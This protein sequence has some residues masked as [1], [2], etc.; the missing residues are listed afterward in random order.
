MTNQYNLGNIAK[1]E[2]IKQ[3]PPTPGEEKQEEMVPLSMLQTLIEEVEALKKG[4]KNLEEKKS[5]DEPESVP[6]NIVRLLEHKDKLVIAYNEKRGTWKQWDKERR[7]DKIFMEIT[8][9]DKDGKEEQAEVDYIGLMDDS[10]IIK[11]PVLSQEEKIIETKG[12]M[13][14]VR[15]VID[16]K[17]IETRNKVQQ[18]VTSSDVTLIIKVPSPYNKELSINARYV[19]IM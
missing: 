7:E 3:T 14:R 6:D 17:T 13:V 11:C 1:K 2:E 10:A 19:N 16:Y 5:V 4:Q 8:L 15:E 9:M 12:Q 18:K